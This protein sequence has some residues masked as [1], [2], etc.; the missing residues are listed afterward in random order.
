MTIWSDKI[1]K[2]PAKEQWKPFPLVPHHGIDIPLSALRSKK[3]SG[4]GEIKDLIPLIDWCSELKI[5]IIQLLPLNDSGNDPSPYNALSSCAINPIYLSLWDLPYLETDKGLQKA[6]D[7]FQLHDHVQRVAYYDVQSHK[8]T[9]LRTYFE[10]FATTFSKDQAFVKYIT[11]N[12]WLKTYGLYKVLKNQLGQNSWLTWPKNLKEL[13][14]AEREELINKNWPEVCFFI[15][16]QYLCYLQLKQVKEYAHQKGVF[17]KGDIPILI[18]PDSSDVW[19]HPEYF[20]LTLAAGAPPDTYNTEGQYWGFPLYVWEVK[21]KS[22][23]SWWKQRLSYASNFYDIFRIDHVVGFFRIWGIP[24]GAPPS[25]GRFIPFD[26]SL[27]LPE[28][29]EHLEMIL[30]YSPMLPIAEDLGLVP[31]EVRETLAELGICGTKVMRWEREWKTDGSY[32]PIQEYP[33]LSMTTVSTHDSET[34][35]QWWTNNPEE[36][37]TYAKF[38]GWIYTPDFTRKMRLSILWDSHHSS[39]IF[40]I[41]LL[42]EYLCL[43]PELSWSNPDEERINI[44]GK[45]LPTNW[46]YRFRP[47]VEEFTSHQRLKEAMQA[48]IYN[49]T[50]L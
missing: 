39:S 35:V 41:N 49:P 36:A 14:T 38:K 47:S 29:R 4:I 32:I 21:K 37:E 17:I 44:P 8:M 48:V 40:H 15:T 20:D 30:R 33:I 9:W 31:T 46:T 3:S 12:P 18:S 25:E 16:L 11:D 23:Y 45:Q 7:E 28:G 2:C 43:F 5:Q 6:L 1:V 10:K 34:L 26:K 50:P 13:S 19:T 42:Q 24:L 22:Q 27:W